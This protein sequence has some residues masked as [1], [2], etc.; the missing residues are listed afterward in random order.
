MAFLKSWHPFVLSVNIS[1]FSPHVYLLLTFSIWPLPSNIYGFWGLICFFHLALFSASISEAPTSLVSVSTIFLQL[2]FRRLEGRLLVTFSSRILPTGSSW[3]LLFTAF[4]VSTDHPMFPLRI[5][6]PHPHSWYRTPRL[7]QPYTSA[8]FCLSL[9]G[10]SKFS[11]SLAILQ[12]HTSIQ[13]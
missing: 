4:F 13:I 5:S 12:S 7:Q 10:Y 6:P 8:S 2:F 3:R 9:S 11:T 1:Q